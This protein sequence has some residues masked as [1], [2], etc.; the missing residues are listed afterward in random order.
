MTSLIKI[1]VGARDSLLSKI[2]VEEVYQELKRYHPELIFYPL[3]IKTQGD[4]D[5]VSSLR[6]KDKTNFFTKELDEMLLAGKCR[7]TIHSAKDLPEPL[8]SGIKLVALT[9]G[10]DSSDA[11]VFRNYETLRPNAI[12]ATSSERREEA[13]KHL[14][15]H[16]RFVDIRGTIDERLEKLYQKEV[17]AVVIAEAALIRLGLKH[18]NRIRLPGESAPLQ[19]RLAILAKEEDH[20]MF[21]LCLCLR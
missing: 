16:A 7:I 5:K 12:V 18:L 19:G 2:Q 9:E 20:E 13:V 4:R 14:F 8:P 15:P 17:D 21:D 3:F 1:T 11:L 6:H 10:V